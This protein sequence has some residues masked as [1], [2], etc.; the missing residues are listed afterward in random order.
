MFPDFIPNMI[1]AISTARGRAH[2]QSFA[3][4]YIDD[5]DAIAHV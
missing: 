5:D 1:R 2:L 4:A 3:I